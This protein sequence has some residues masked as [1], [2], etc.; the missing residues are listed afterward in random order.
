[1]NVASVS[2]LRGAP[3]QGVYGMTK[4]A[5]ISMTRTLAVELA[6]ARIRVNTIAPGLI[7]TRLASALVKTRH[8]P[9]SG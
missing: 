3:L 2:G 6:A 9:A 7:D 8:T 5:V 4:A 1:M